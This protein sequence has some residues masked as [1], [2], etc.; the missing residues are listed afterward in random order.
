MSLRK[1]PFEIMSTIAQH[2]DPD[3]IFHLS[4]SCRQF[5]YLIHDETICK[6]ALESAARFAPETQAARKSKRYASA[7]RRLVKRREAISSAKPYLVALVAVA[8]SYLF[9]NGLL[10]YI[11]EGRLRV[12]D[13]HRS[14]RSEIVIDIRT[15]LTEEIDGYQDTKKNRFYLLHYAEGVVSCLYSQG[16][17]AAESWLVVLSL[18]E[19]R[20]LTT[21]SLESSHKIFV[22]NNQEY[23]YYGT[24]T[25]IGEDDYRRW[26]LQGYSICSGEWFDQKIHL[27]DMVGSDIGSSI[28]FEIID[29]HFYGLSNQTS[30][31]VEEMDWTSFYHSFKFPVDSPKPKHTQISCK[32]SMWRRQHAEGPIDDRWTFIRLQKDENSGHLKVVESRKEWL[33]G[34]RSGRR[35]YYTTDL[36]FPEGEDEE[37]V[38]TAGSNGQLARYNARDDLNNTSGK[39]TVPPDVSHAAPKRCPYGTHPGD[40]ASSSLLFTF[41]RCFLLSY[42]SASQTF[43]DLVDDPLPSN[44][45][46]QRLRVRAGSRRLRPADEICKLGLGA[47]LSTQDEI[48]KLFRAKGENTVTFWPPDSDQVRPDPFLDA[49]IDDLYRVLNPPTFDGNV[50]GTWDDRSLIYSTGGRDNGV[51][52]IVFVSFDPAVYL[53]GLPRWSGLQAR[54]K[55]IDQSPQRNAV[56]DT[57]EHGKGKQIDARNCAEEALWA[58]ETCSACLPES[59]GLAIHHQDVFGQKWGWVENAMYMSISSETPYGYI[60]AQ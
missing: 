29:G 32:Q 43:L 13:L 54:T 15:L 38:F 37:Y 55:S 19:N 25:D 28:C 52:A 48:N 16:R 5:D 24:H 22:R 14:S 2:L 6:A 42:H 21:R 33:A 41:S 56:Y 60:L 20:V 11:L 57:G 36:V 30:F 45:N 47:S 18:R 35:T 40:D 1:L 31:E 17:P 58:T 46:A 39:V 51:Q 34:Q 12:L 27:L 7:L 53:H 10:C 26:V 44:T 3:D 49:A 9:A 50:Y 23:L 59:P 4:L 8:E